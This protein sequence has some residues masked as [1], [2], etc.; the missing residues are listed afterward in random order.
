M[1]QLTGQIINIEFPGLFS[2]QDA[3]DA[4][5]VQ[6]Y[7]TLRHMRTSFAAA[8]TAVN[9][10]AGAVRQNYTIVAARLL[11]GPSAITASDTNFVTITVEWN[12]GAGGARTVALTATTKITGGTGN[13]AADTAAPLTVTVASSANVIPAGSVLYVKVVASGTGTTTASQIEF[14]MV[15]SA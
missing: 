15:P 8:G 7:T 11:N 5:M 1:G 9:Q 3:T 4:T 2:A 10:P 13:V 6:Q 12:N 14:D